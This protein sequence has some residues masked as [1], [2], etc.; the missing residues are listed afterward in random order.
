MLE[1]IQK[2]KDNLSFFKIPFEVKVFARKNF[3][4]EINILKLIE[5]VTFWTD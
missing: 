5:R 3:N 1:K 2:F 4:L